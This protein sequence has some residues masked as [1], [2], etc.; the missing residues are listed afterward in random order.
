[1][2]EEEFKVYRVAEYPNQEKGFIWDEQKFAKFSKYLFTA[3][4]FGYLSGIFLNLIYLLLWRKGKS[5][6]SILITLFIDCLI[7][8]IILKNVFKLENKT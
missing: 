1:M 7:I 8:I 6:I 5:I 2:E 3:P 4:I